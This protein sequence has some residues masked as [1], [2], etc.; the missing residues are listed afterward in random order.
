MKRLPLLYLGGLF[1]AGALLGCGGDVFAP[2]A[3]TLNGTWVRLNDIPGSGER[4][5]L[6]VHGSTIS[7]SGTWTGE[8]CCEGTLTLTGTIV[9]DSIHV[10]VTLVTTAPT[11][12]RSFHEHF[13]G[14]LL[15]RNLLRGLGSVENGPSGEVR[16][17]RS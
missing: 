9:L 12:D 2:S 14:A 10:D 6:T 4:W 15:S 17:Q 13:D 7:G 8:A 3:S 1:A 11:A 5:N 16:F